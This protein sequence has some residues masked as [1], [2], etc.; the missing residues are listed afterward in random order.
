[1]RVF[2]G[3]LAGTELWIPGDSGDEGDSGDVL[4][5]SAI[6]WVLADHAAVLRL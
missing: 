6:G 5:N 4:L 1:M 2:R 3:A